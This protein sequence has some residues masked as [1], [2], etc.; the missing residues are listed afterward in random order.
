M[1]EEIVGQKIT[2]KLLESK[3]FDE[4][5]GMFSSTVR[6]ILGLPETATLEETRDFLSKTV[7]ALNNGENSKYKAFYCV[8][9]NLDGKLI[10]ALDIRE[11]GC[12][13]GQLGTWINE[14]YWGSGRYQEV[15]N[16][17]LKAYFRSNDIDT[18]NAYVRVANIRSLKAHQKYGF[19]IV[20]ELEVNCNDC[21][22]IVITR[23]KVLN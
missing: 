1:P 7:E 17:G 19:E 4:Y 9:D 20:G 3:Y 23:D 11:P 15:L 21:Y 14:N 2:L 5:H 6:I 18:I 13:D 22:E 10:G 12:K 8:F 16:L